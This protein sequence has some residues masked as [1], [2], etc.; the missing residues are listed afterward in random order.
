MQDIS[1]RAGTM[2]NGT[3]GGMIPM[4][5]FTPV[6]AI[7]AVLAWPIPG[8]IFF[9]LTLALS[10]YLI[11]SAVR[12]LKLSRTMPNE[13]NADDARIGKYMPIISSIMGVG[14]LIAVV[15]FL[16]LDAFQW[17]IPTVAA[18]VGLHFFP[19]ANLFQR[20][21]DYYLTLLMLL[22]AAAGLFLLTQGTDWQFAW[23]VTGIIS[24][25]VTATYGLNA[26]TS[27]GQVL[28]AYKTL[29]ASTGN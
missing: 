28:T 23:A 13:Q 7:W 14:I 19:M 22:G 10:A 11:V 27:A 9:V 3:A 17:I 6:Y 24:A 5:I 16:V 20:T 2:L 26:V 29:P 25:C 18:I 1:T 4:A 15:V 21:I 8:T 12:A